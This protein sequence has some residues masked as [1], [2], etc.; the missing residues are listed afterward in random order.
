MVPLE[1]TD[2]FDGETQAIRWVSAKEARRLIQ[3]N[4]KPKRRRRDLRVLKSALSLFRS[5]SPLFSRRSGSTITQA[6]WRS[7]TASIWIGSDGF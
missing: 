4:L 5:W 7:R 3:L 6:G 1:D 2:H